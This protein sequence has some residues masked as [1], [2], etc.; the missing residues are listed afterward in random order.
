MFHFSFYFVHNPS[1]CGSKCLNNIRNSALQN[2]VFAKI[3][4]NKTNTQAEASIAC[5]QR[6]ITAYSRICLIFFFKLFVSHVL[7]FMHCCFLLPSAKHRGHNLYEQ[8]QQRL[9]TRNLWFVCGRAKLKKI[10]RS[11][12]QQ[13]LG[14]FTFNSVRSFLSLS[15]SANSAA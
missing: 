2:I 5:P 10:K 8:Q 4:Q 14:S 9:Y 1:M 11:G 6:L 7:R 12:K 15:I 3:H 13:I